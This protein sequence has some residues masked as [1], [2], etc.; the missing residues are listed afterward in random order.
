MRR[1]EF[2]RAAL[3]GAVLVPGLSQR[4]MAAV[5]AGLM[6][7]DRDLEALTRDGGEQILVHAV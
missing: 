3:A 5:Y 6:N 2:C 1:R 4:T 7:V